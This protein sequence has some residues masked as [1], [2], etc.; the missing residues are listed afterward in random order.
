MA[1]RARAGGPLG[2]AVQAAVTTD[3]RRPLPCPP[4]KPR[5]N[6][7]TPLR[8]HFRAGCRSPALPAGEER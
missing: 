3:P 1:A 8:R 5:E 7:V 4:P 2:P 6:C